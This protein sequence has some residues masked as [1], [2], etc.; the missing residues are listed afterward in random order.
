MKNNGKYGIGSYYQNG[1]KAH[2]G[3]K[4]LTNFIPFGGYLLNLES[5]FHNADSSASST[6]L[7][8]SDTNSSIISRSNTV[9]LLSFSKYAKNWKFSIVS[10]SLSILG[11]FTATH[12]FKNDKKIE[13][14]M[15]NLTKD[16]FRGCVSDSAA[17]QLGT[18]LAAG[19]IYYYDNM[20]RLKA[21]GIT[22]DEWAE[23]IRHST[24]KILGKYKFE[25]FVKLEDYKIK[26]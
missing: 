26:D 3:T 9:D 23:R 10:T 2:L 8:D 22:E 17:L 13:F 14:F 12:D 18:I 24:N 15:N 11:V 1:S 6:I 25:S 5:V 20:E 4:C 19:A 16:P 7:F 21:K